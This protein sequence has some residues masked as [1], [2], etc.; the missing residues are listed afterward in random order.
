MANSKLTLASLISFALSLFSTANAFADI[1]KL[2]IP[3]L[4]KKMAAGELSSVKLTQFYLQQIES[5]NPKLHAVITVNPNA[6]EDAQKSD[7][8][9]KDAASN[10]NKLGLLHGIPVLLKDNIDTADGM[11]TTGGSVLLKNHFPQKDAFVVTQLRNAG[12]II[13]GK[14]NLS[15][16]ANFRST[17]SSSGWS[18]MGGQTRNPYDITR[19]PCGSSSG[20]GVAVAANMTQIAI[21]TETDGSIICPSASNGV[22]GFKPTVGLVSRTGIIPISSNHDTAGPMARSVT[23]AVFLLQ[24]MLGND[25]QDGHSFTNKALSNN[26]LLKH[27]KADGLKGKRIGVVSNYQS[28]HPEVNA[29]FKRS[30]GI[31]REAGAIIVEDA[32]IE[33]KGKWRQHQYNTL[34]WDFKDEI[35]SYLSTTKL[36]AKSLNDLIVLNKTHSKDELVVFGQEIFETANQTKGKNEPNY[37]KNL[38]EMMAMVRE[39]GIDATMKKHDL[40]ILI[41]P[42]SGPAWKID[43]INGDHFQGSATSPAAISGYPHIT[44]PMGYVLHL[45]VGISF[46]AGKNSEPTLI[47]AAYH[48]E[49]A[50]KVR[51]APHL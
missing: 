9:R 45:P 42:T 27:L 13:L 49:Q 6:L 25:A 14:A 21:G 34:L 40:D 11:P 51:R 32:P 37:Q 22:V 36:E 2:T 1:D 43:P 20:S 30:V 23:D 8:K 4:H 10:N 3:D 33:T 19:T 47:E 7:K 50:T 48:F 24:S 38:S 35:A 39:Q 5:L 16:W 12:A 29:I 18:G 31:M 15:E 46:F 44:V 41:A 26:G 17:R 28:A